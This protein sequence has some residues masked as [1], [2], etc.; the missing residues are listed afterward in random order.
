MNKQPARKLHSEH[1]VIIKLF[2]QRS[3]LRLSNRWHVS[4]K[5]PNDINVC[6]IECNECNWYKHDYIL[7]GNLNNRKVIVIC[8]TFLQLNKIIQISELFFIAVLFTFNQTLSKEQNHKPSIK[9]V[10]ILHWKSP[11]THLEQ[12]VAASH[13]TIFYN[14]FGKKGTWEFQMSL[15][16][17]E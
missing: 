16:R 11:K 14:D 6:S 1:Q 15:S 12:P 10:E 5:F 8:N 3:K 13:Q 4:Q 7:R 9:E 2:F 17:R